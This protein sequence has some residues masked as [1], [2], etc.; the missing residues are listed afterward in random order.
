MLDS[1]RAF[2]LC[3]FYPATVVEELMEKYQLL[4]IDSVK[5]RDVCP[6][7]LKVASLL[8]WIYV[9][10]FFFIHFRD[11]RQNTVTSVGL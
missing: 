10:F 3:T 4:E 2:S 11:L 8:I 1:L 5:K 6:R 9:F 7:F